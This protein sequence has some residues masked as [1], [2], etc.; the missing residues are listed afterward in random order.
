MTWAC[1]E[2]GSDDLGVAVVTSANLYQQPEDDNYQTEV[3]GDHEWD[4]DSTMWCH[5][6]G[7]VATA[8][9]FEVPASLNS[10]PRGPMPRRRMG[11]FVR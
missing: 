5:A 2:C 8:R 1:S 9:A 3:Q 6:C 11:D 7:E 4:A 10:D